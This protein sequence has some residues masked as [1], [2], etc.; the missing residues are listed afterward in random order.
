MHPLTAYLALAAAPLA[1]F[2]APNPVRFSWSFHNGL[3]PMPRITQE[4]AERADRYWY[5]IVDAITIAFV[6]GLMLWNG[7]Q[8]SRA[9]LHLENWKEGVSLGIVAG[10]LRLLLI[11]TLVKAFPRAAPDRTG[12]H[13]LWIGSFS[14]WTTIFLS[15]AFSEELWIAFCLV[16][17]MASGHSMV[18]SVLLTAGV[19]GAVH[20]EYRF[21]AV[22]TAIY[23][24]VSALLFLWLR[25]LIPM[26]LFHF[27]GNM[28]SLYWARRA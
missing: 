22:A 8:P 24:C 28:G 21:G 11:G 7:V 5:F 14:L 26:F 18:A 4:K 25:S 19:F 2:L 13:R 17:L 12:P 9:G 23:G 10:T 6:V 27:I 15:G 1:T 20:F 3:E 16:A